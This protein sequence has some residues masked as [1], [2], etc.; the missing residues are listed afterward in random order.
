MKEIPII[1]SGPMVR[2]I[3]EGR[4]T[5]FRRVVKPQPQRLTVDGW[6]FGNKYFADDERMMDHLF[7]NVYGNG[8]CPYGSVYADFDSDLLW[9][10]ETWLKL[11]RDGWCDP[12]KPKCWFD[13]CYNRVN[14]IAY[15][16]SCDAEGERIRREYG[17][18]WRS[19]ICMPRWASRLTLGV[20]DIRVERLQD[21]SDADASAEG[22]VGQTIRTQKHLS[23]QYPAAAVFVQHWDSINAKRGHPWHSNP[24][25]WVIEFEVEEI[26]GGQSCQSNATST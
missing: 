5:Q 13:D 20:V 7:H 6:M 16:A 2:A 25:V 21:I 14:A 19:P 26:K 9:V 15:R 1:F 10:R 23:R 18:K 8:Q 17:Y 11:D 22:F 3:L 24:W 4:K 12:S